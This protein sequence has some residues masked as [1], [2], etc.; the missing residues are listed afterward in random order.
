MCGSSELRA[1]A[2]RWPRAQGG[3]ERGPGQVRWG[4]IRVRTSPAGMPYRAQRPTSLRIDR[5]AIRWMDRALPWLFFGCPA[6]VLVALDRTGIAL[7]WV[8]A[9]GLALAY[10]QRRVIEL[11][12]DASG[13]SVTHAGV[14]RLVQQVQ[15]HQVQ[16]VFWAGR[17]ARCAV[18]ARTPE[19]PTL[20]FDHVDP[21]QARALEE[22]I[23]RILGLDGRRKEGV[24]AEL[25]RRVEENVEGHAC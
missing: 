4:E 1:G 23:E 22:K 6:F 24:E 21:V 15:R 5:P 9:V 18:W 3:T 8:T 16:R 20:L 25:E 13:L 12:A 7:A 17:G 10:L 19:G 11:R 2:I 14:R